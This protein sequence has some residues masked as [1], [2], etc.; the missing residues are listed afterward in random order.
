MAWADDERTHIQSLPSSA[1]VYNKKR[2][3]CGASL[4]KR[5]QGKTKQHERPAGWLGDGLIDAG[6]DATAGRLAK[7]CPP[8]VVLALDMRGS[9]SFAPNN[10]VGCIDHTVTVKVASQFRTGH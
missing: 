2:S 9:Q 1:R 8:F 10:I 3:T 7:R 4:T 5:Q 6:R